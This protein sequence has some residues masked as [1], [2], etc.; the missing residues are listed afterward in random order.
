MF[1][2]IPNPESC[3]F[4][5]F[6][7]GYAAASGT[8]QGA[9]TYLVPSSAS[10]LFI[11]AIGP[12]GR[13]GNGFTGAA[14]T[15]RGGGGGGGSG[16]ISRLLI[17]A[18]MLP[19][20]L[21]MRPGL[22]AHSAILTG[23]ASVVTTY[24]GSSG[25]GLSAKGLILQANAGG[26]GG[27]GTGSAG[28]TAGA[29]GTASTAATATFQ[30]LGIV[31]WQA[32]QAGTAGGAHT[33]AAG[34]ALVWGGTTVL[35]ISGGSGGGG[36]PTT[37]TDF[38]G[39]NITGTTI[40]TEEPLMPTLV[41]GLA[42]AGRGN[43]GNLFWYDGVRGFR[44]TGGTGGGTAGASGTGGRGGDGAYCCGGGGGGGG[45][46]GGTGGAG[47]PGLIFVWAW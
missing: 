37:N 34:T 5:V 20:T 1:G 4:Q 29:A 32:G 19:K 43:N 31:T 26:N 11:L 36:T 7:G 45:V 18:K 10:M 33:G 41:G 9:Q 35:P 47:G 25:G 27:N 30:N 42:A 13:G 3:D 40:V 24:P 21:Y 8:G 6:K 46:T 38:A 44:A 12:G 39:G 14:G 2:T 22:A 28:G 16:A 15:A 17:P 23:Q